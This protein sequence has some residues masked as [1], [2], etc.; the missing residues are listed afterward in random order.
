MTEPSFTQWL[1]GEVAT[2]KCILLSL[3]EQR[4]KLQYIDGPRLERAYMEIVGEFEQTVLQEE[5]E[6]ELLKRKQQMIQTAMNR[7]ECIDESKIDA[8]LD[9]ERQK[10][11]QDAK[12]ADAPSEFADLTSEKQDE[13]HELYKDIVR[14]F[15][16]Q[17]HPEISEAQREL[18]QKAQAAYRRRDLDSMR[19]IYD[20]LM[21]TQDSGITLDQFLELL[22]NA[23]NGQ[24][25]TSSEK[26]SAKSLPDY[27]LASQL[28]SCFMCTADEAILEDELVRYKRLSD[29]VEQEMMEIKKEFPYIAADLLEDPQQLEAYK[30]SLERRLQNAREERQRREAEIRSMMEGAATHE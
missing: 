17:T 26:E 5:M 6:C 19:L 16:P 18:F 13:L 29:E 21:G 22:M 15:H 2:A 9:V 20:M 1:Q 8:Q 7:R 25:E 23:R 11:I 3:Y 30:A 4:D 28:F 12:G 24:E 14:E 27:S 10:M